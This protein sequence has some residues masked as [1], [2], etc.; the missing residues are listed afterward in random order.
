[1]SDEAPHSRRGDYRAARIGAGAALVSALVVLLFI[2]ALSTEYEVSPAVLG[3]L[4]T[5]IL[6]LFGIEAAS[7]L[8]GE[9]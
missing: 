2:D 3:T 9:K 7:F 5:M 6:V 1:M 8:R 4:A